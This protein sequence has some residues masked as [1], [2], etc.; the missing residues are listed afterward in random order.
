MIVSIRAFSILQS[1]KELLSYKNASASVVLSE[2]GEL[3]GKIFTENRTNI[4]YDQLPKHLI[5]ALVATEDAR[6]FKH[7]GIDSRSLVR[8][9]FKTI[10]FRNKNSG[11]GSTITEQL[12]KNMF[13]RK[14]KG[15]FAL[16]I[17]KTK[18]AMLAR[19][20]EKVFTKE[21]IITLYLNTVPFGE[22]VYG[23]DAASRRYFSKTTGTLKIEES[24]VLIGILKANNLYNPRLYPANAKSRRNI[25]LGQMQKYK[26]LTAA[27]SDSL[28]KMPLVL[29]YVNLE[30][31][32][33]ADYFLY[34]VKNATSP[35][36]TFRR[37]RSPPPFDEVRPC[38]GSSGVKSSPT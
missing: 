10:L 23:I 5:N 2:N 4:T 32:G 25:V 20:L 22:N 26:Y 3:I 30:S 21:E 37:H 33:P 18:E 27:Q 9:F 35:A 36:I 34:Q 24:A 8:V 31:A 11:G 6:Y 29:N 28:R 38:I 7:K 15:P 16:F 19:R 1:E 17:N 14:N 12:A 13:G